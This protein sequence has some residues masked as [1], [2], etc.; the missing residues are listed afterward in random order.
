MIIMVCSVASLMGAPPLVKG[1]DYVIPI[2]FTI[3]IQMKSKKPIKLART[4]DNKILELKDVLNDPISVYLKGLA[5]GVAT[6][7]LVSTDDEKEELSV[8]VLRQQTPVNNIK[9]LKETTIDMAHLKKVLAQAVPNTKVEINLVTTD[10]VF[11]KGEVNSYNDMRTILHVASK[12]VDPSYQEK[13]VV[14]GLTYSLKDDEDKEIT[15]VSSKVINGLKLKPKKPIDLN[16]LKKTLKQ[17]VPTGN[18]D[19]VMITADSVFISGEVNSSVEQLIVLQ[20]ASKIVDPSYQEKGKVGNT[21]NLND[22]KGQSI[23]TV[24][25]NVLNGI[26]L[27]RDG[28][29]I[30]PKKEI[31][32]EELNKVLS[33]AVPT[34]NINVKMITA[35]SVFI[36]GEV[37]SFI[38]RLIILQLASK[39]VD[40]DYQEKGKE[41]T[42]YDLNDEKGQSLGTVSFKVINGLKVLKPNQDV[43]PKKQS[44]TPT[45]PTTTFDLDYLK[46]VIRDAVPNS[47]IQIIPVTKD[48]VILSGYVSRAEDIGMI[49]SIA[50][51]IVDPT[52]FD[53]LSQS[54]STQTNN[55]GQTNPSTPPASNIPTDPNAA[56]TTQPAQNAQKNSPK[57]INALRV[58]GVQQV[59]LDVVVA[60]VSRTEIRKLAFDFLT[61]RN[62]SF[63][64]STLSGLATRPLAMSQGSTLAANA[65]VASGAGANVPFGVLNSSSGFLGFLQALRTETASKLLAEPKL[66]T[67]SGKKA[68]FLVGG[69]QAVISASSGVNGPGVDFKKIG[70]QL[71]F[72]PI[73]LGNG[74]IQLTVNPSIKSVNISLGIASPTPGGGFTPGFDDKQV[75]ATVEMETG[76]TFVIGGLIQNETRGSNKKIP[77]LGDL[78][79][80]GVLFSSKEFT[81]TEQEVVIL[82]TPYLVDPQS[83]DQLPKLLPGQETRSPDDFELFLEGILEA[84]RGPRKVIQDRKY[85]PAF[86]NAKPLD[87]ESGESRVPGNLIFPTRNQENVKPKELPIIETQP[88]PLP[89]P[90]PVPEISKSEK[91]SEVPLVQ[92]KNS[93]SSL[94]IKVLPG[95]V[96][97]NN[98]ESNNKTSSL[99]TLSPV[100]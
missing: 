14:P 47:N 95:V 90:I 66:V 60:Q 57:V 55:P 20:L 86:K 70:T 12:I 88:V 76:Q 98:S 2:D 36:S 23:G 1:P 62:S 73:V 68:S 49:L 56:A 63:I 71:D 24:S 74:K 29:K 8:Y 16:E 69:E 52:L 15:T 44:A 13:G 27:R 79:F 31:D 77:V 61:Y 41:G 43:E 3:K 97:P 93:R 22:E 81:E 85:I 96:N 40:P 25:F 92:I 99:Q 100:K 72:L 78:P 48:A 67:S 50:S 53:A 11:V 37:N 7:E 46:K 30:K 28:L 80:L 33:Q 65:F 58:A 9:F 5:E 94:P 89:V 4:F 87:A 64:G 59:Q 17:A 19:V 82:V 21:Y 32:I 54:S 83:C 38:E 42:T 18:I 26:K 34:G 45:P 91:V 51:N 35:D 10:S 6:L 39:I 84:P 75:T